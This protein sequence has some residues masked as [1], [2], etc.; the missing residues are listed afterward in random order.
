MHANFKDDVNLETRPLITFLVLSCES[1]DGCTK[2]LKIKIRN[3]LYSV[4][5]A[6]CKPEDFCFN[7]MMPKS[8]MKNGLCNKR[9]RVM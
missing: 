8:L 3:E 9:P 2:P 6:L 5:I 7:G 1:D 4:K